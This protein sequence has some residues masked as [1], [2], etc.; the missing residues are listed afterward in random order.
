MRHRL[1]LGLVPIVALAL[2]GPRAGLAQPAIQVYVDGQIVNFD[3]PAT[4]INGRVLV[5]LRGVFE[6]LGAT[7]DY[8]TS[9]QHIVALRGGQAVE[10]TIG[11]RQARVNNLPALLDVPA[12][13]IAG[14][15]MVP[16]RF[17]SEALGAGVQWVDTSRTIL[18]TSAAAAFPAPS[19]SPPA[20]S[21]AP[22]APAPPSYVPPP[23]AQVP[24]ITGQLVSVVTGTTPFIVVAAAGQQYKLPV[25]PSATIAR[26]N[27]DTRAGGPVGLEAL[28]PGD[29]VTVTADPRYEATRIVA[30]YRVAAQ[31]P[32][33]PPPP[34]AVQ[35]V[36]GKIVDANLQ[37]RTARLD[38]GRTVT[39]LSD[40]YIAHDRGPA[41]FGA[42]A[43]GRLGRFWVLGGTDQAVAVDVTERMEVR[44]VEGTIVDAN[45][46]ARTARLA[47]GG[48][49]T[50]AP[51]IHVTRNGGPTDFGAVAAGRLGRLW[52]I[53]GT[54][55]AVAIDLADTAAGPGSLPRARIIEGW[56]VDANFRARTVRLAN[57]QTLAVFGDAFV[58]RNNGPTDFGAVA[59]GRY[60][61]FWV[62][63]GTTQA[64]LVDLS[65]PIAVQVLTG[66]IVDVNFR[67]RTFR[68][69]NGQ[70]FTVPDNVY[71]ARNGG[72][73][74]FGAVAAGR[75]GTFWVI[76]GT[77]Q[78]FLVDL[79]D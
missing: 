51:N 72:R 32:A 66:K 55:E 26:Y 3:V 27:A 36:A 31:A 24:P 14:R 6:R 60:G 46:K 37:A 23:P 15:T 2:A 12:F 57:G 5:P 33:P 79:R 68:L 49:F 8:D 61:R 41:G 70:T 17:V 73:T 40:A 64:F 16:L 74:D 42:I 9:T 53:D 62:T 50:T 43:A 65:E 13:T 59:A 1:L 54:N 25:A 56:I 35:V 77:N 48:V 4:V 28:Q 29:A 47:A 75:S 58:A 7:V 63:A 39:V 45:F 20:P 44:P 11:S 34:F 52:V 71:I 76:Q 19:P 67:A 21:Y 18:I 22:P 30:F 10:L 69:A 38:N 78:A